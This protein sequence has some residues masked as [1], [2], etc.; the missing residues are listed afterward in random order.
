MRDDATTAIVASARRRHELTRAKAIQALRELERT[1]AAVSFAA[2]A[3]AARISRS[4]L[5]T[6]LDLAAEITRLREAAADR[7]KSS[8]IPAMQRASDAR[9]CAADW[10]WRNNASAD[11]SGTT[12]SCAANS[13]TRWATD[14]TRAGAHLPQP[15]PP[16]GRS[17][18][19]GRV[20]AGILLRLH[21]H[22]GE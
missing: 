19:R 7:P 17:R 12:S 4:W 14:A 21:R 8:A 13:L 6:E 22:R 1:G 20:A 15:H 2:V 5:Y 9:R 18:S 3:K 11:C 10:S 16:T